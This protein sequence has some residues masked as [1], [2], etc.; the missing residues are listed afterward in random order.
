MWVYVIPWSLTFIAL[1]FT[2]LTFLRNG[3]RDS[4]RDRQ[5]QDLKFEALKESMLKANIKLDQVCNTMNEMRNDVKTLNLAMVE[6]DKRLSVVENDLK[7]A[8][9]RIDELKEEVRI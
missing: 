4:M 7:I 8:F 9:Q 6:M 2:I 3:R 1:I 5:E